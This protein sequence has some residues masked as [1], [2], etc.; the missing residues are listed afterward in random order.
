MFNPIFKENVLGKNIQGVVY[1]N[2]T[3]FLQNNLHIDGLVQKRR[4]PIASALELR[5]LALIH[6]YVAEIW[7]V[8]FNSNYL[9]SEFAID[10]WHCVK[11]MSTII[12]KYSL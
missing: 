9:C 10:V 5:F 2:T 12:L 7:G 8:C 6:R 11:N 4:N 3:N 1:V